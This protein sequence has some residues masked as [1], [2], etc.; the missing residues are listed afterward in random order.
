MDRFIRSVRGNTLVLL[1][2]VFV[3]FFIA[4]WVRGLI[5]ILIN[6]IF[7]PLFGNKLNLVSFWGYGFENMNDKWTY[8][9]KKSS[10]GIRSYVIFDCE[11]FGN[12]DDPDEK[13]KLGKKSDGYHIF[14]SWII[15]VLCLVLGLVVIFTANTSMDSINTIICA[16]GAGLIYHG[17]F[18]LIVG[19]YSSHKMKTSLAGYIDNAVK[20]L[21]AGCLIPNLE[22]LP[23]N[24]L[25]YEKTIK[26]ERLLYF[27]F[28]FIYLDACGRFDEMKAVVD[29]ANDDLPEQFSRPIAN[30]YIQL[31][32]YYSCH[33]VDEV[34]ARY[35]YE[36]VG[37]FLVND[38]DSNSR[39]IMAYFELNINKNR[40][41]AIE[42]AKATKNNLNTFKAKVSAGEYHY[43][44]ECVDR[45]YRVLGI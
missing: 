18:L 22:L 5:E 17:L 4:S 16:L 6:F 39:R 23:V 34:K 28:Y 8:V 26:A 35:F 43:E 44:I 37:K 19:Y 3:F 1:V 14:Y 45:L 24:L 29:A 42:Y 25:P 7:A 20:K 10:L 11:K 38:R 15:F 36:N 21:R 40:E 13:K 27:P 32:Y 2:T 9:G 31:M 41:A 12:I 33:N 30:A